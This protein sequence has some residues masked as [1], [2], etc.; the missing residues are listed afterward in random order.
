M[1]Q[2]NYCRHIVLANHGRTAESQ[3]GVPDGFRREP[4][5]TKLWSIRH[6]LIAASKTEISSGGCLG[7]DTRHR[8]G[9]LG[10]GALVQGGVDLEHQT[11]FAEHL[12]LRTTF[13]RDQSGLDK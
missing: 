11:G 7:D 2:P 9:G 1:N 13:R 3:Y 8:L 6:A 4:A 5:S 10:D 12:C